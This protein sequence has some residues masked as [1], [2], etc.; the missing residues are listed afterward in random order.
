MDLTDYFKY[1][2]T[3]SLLT[4]LFYFKKYKSKFYIFFILY[5]FFAIIADVVG[6][7]YS[8]TN[9]Y[10]VFD[11]YTFFEFGSLFG[12]Y[13]FLIEN[14]KTRIIMSLIS[15]V[16]YSILFIGIKY[17]ILLRNAPVY[18]PFFIVSFIFLY[19]KQ[20]LNSNQITNY[21]KILPFWLSVALLIFYLGGLPFFTLLYIGNLYGRILFSIVFFILLIM[22]IIFILSLIWSKPIQK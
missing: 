4:A 19:L 5:L 3:A 13:Y 15:I 8:G 14:K 12:I 2:E 6:G 21:K 9:N 18:M 1:I 11:I 20:L 16:F 17:S 22:H 7:Y 10:W